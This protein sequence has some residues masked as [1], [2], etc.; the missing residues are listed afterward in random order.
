MR[1]SRQFWA[2]LFFLWKSFERKKSTH[3]Q[4]S[5]SKTKLSKHSQKS[6][7]KTKL[8]KHSITKATFFMRAKTERMKVVC[9]AFYDFFYTQNLFLK[10]NKQAWNSLDNLI[11][12]YCWRVPL[13]A[14]LLRIICT[15]LFLFAIIYENLFLLWEYI[16][17][18]SIFFICDFLSLYENK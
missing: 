16:L 3:K 17:F 18:M 12:L 5:T 4:K 13:S 15:H 14:H 9:F 7:N 11:I 8:S 2:C 1:L 6:T 10:T